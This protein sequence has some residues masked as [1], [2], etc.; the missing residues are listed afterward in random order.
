MNFGET[1]VVLPAGE[2]VL[3]SAELTDDGL[4][5]ADATAWVR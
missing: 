3:A 4:L 2:V 5:P 1:P